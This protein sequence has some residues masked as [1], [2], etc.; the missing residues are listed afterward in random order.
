[1]KRVLSPFQEYIA[2]VFL[3]SLF[4]QSCG[5]TQN[6]L[7]E[8][9]AV[10]IQSQPVLHSI[11]PPILSQ[12]LVV[13]ELPDQES[14]MVRDDQGEEEEEEDKSLPQVLNID[15]LVTQ[16]HQGDPDA[17]MKIIEL[18]QN[19][20]PSAQFNLGKMYNNGLGS[21][22]KNYTK[23]IEWYEKAADQGYASAQQNLGIMYKTGKGVAK[24]YAKAFEWFEKA[25]NQG[26]RNAQYTLGGMYYQG[27]GL[28]KDYAKAFEWLEKAADQGDADAQLGL[29][30][31]YHCGEGVVKDEVKAVEWLRK[32][33]DQDLAEAQYTLG[34]LYLIGE[35]VDKDEVKAVEWLRKAADQ[36]FLQAKFI[37]GVRYIGSEISVVNIFSK[38]FSMHSYPKEVYEDY[39]KGL[40]CY[41]KE[42]DQGDAES[43]YVLGMV[44][45]NGF[46]VAKD[47]TKA[48]KWYQKAADQ[49][50]AKAQAKLKEWSCILQ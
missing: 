8:A 10:S 12:A 50:H 16:A 4:S 9:K 36:G 38:M 18:S 23:A 20:H 41:Q 48:A 19:H 5:G 46:G 40:E 22:P 28:A 32:A 37:L 45:D 33:A 11:A 25:A 39:I 47:K 6:P 17:L 27:E 26:N 24:D 13:Q 43:Q 30:L 3:V 42:A 34:H 31:I 44:Y 15:H 7:P 29:A 49:G 21:I 35:G 2:C 1:M 14:G